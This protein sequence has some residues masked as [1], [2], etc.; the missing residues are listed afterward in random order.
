MRLDTTPEMASAQS[1]YA[2]L[3]FR[4]IPPYRENPVPGTRFLELTL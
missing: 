4:D 3:G 2:R 1:L